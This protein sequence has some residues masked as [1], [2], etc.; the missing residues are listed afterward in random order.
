MVETHKLSRGCQQVLCI[1]TLLVLRGEQLLRLADVFF[2]GQQIGHAGMRVAE[3]LCGDAARVKQASA[4]WSR[5]ARHEPTE[6]IREPEN[7]ISTGLELRS[8]GQKARLLE[9]VPN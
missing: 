8:V 5:A 6:L 9:V 3:D 4:L 7:L 2:A 1:G